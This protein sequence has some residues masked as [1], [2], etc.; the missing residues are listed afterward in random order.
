MR[1]ILYLAYGHVFLSGKMKIWKNEQNYKI[2]NKSTRNNEKSEMTS[3][4]DPNNDWNWSI[5]LK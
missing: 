1:H 2:C 3:G 4:N 5:N